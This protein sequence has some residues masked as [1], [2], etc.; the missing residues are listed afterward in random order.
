ML[1]NFH[2][3][4]TTARACHEDI[5]LV[6]SKGLDRAR[7]LPEFRAIDNFA[8]GRSLGTRGDVGKIPEVQECI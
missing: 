2:V 1:E 7:I 5:H 6:I 3:T 8:D 4:E